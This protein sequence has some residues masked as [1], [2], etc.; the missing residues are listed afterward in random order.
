MTEENV[1]IKDNGAATAAE[2]NTETNT[3][4]ETKETNFDSKAFI[5]DDEP[6]K[7]TETNEDK[8]KDKDASSEE[9]S[10]EA[11]TEVEDTSSV[12][13]GGESFSWDLFDEKPKEPSKE[14]PAKEAESEAQ[15]ATGGD[16]S[17]A[18]SGK[19]ELAKVAE[20]FDIQ[21]DSVDDII[22]GLK[23]QIASVKPAPETETIK[24]LNSLLSLKDKDLITEDLKSSGFSDEEITEYLEKLEDNDNL[25]FEAKKLRNN[26]KNTISNEEQKAKKD[27]KLQEEARKQE[28]ESNQ[29]EL[30]KYINDNDEVLGIKMTTDADKLK[31]MKDGHYE[32]ITSGQFFGE[33]TESHKN[34]SEA[35]WVWK[36]RE[37][38]VQIAKNKGFEEGKESVIN[39]LKNPDLG[40]GANHIPDGKE[41]KDFNPAKFIAG[42]SM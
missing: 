36:N 29:V 2:T 30:K 23:K 4:Q 34:L 6:D 33:V 40:D 28:L 1:D 37:K 20:A 17:K 11:K 38:L 32:Y 12:K 14:E 31:S 16:T 18:A 10:T 21:A 15:V 3:E 24:T 5:S 22:T 27:I 25:R 42:D 19:S 8:D 39:D 13:E 9:N 26:I 7:S 35:A 41:D